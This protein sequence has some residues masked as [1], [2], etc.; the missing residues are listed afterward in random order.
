MYRKNNSLDV[1]IR[2]F[3]TDRQR[4]GAFAPRSG[5]WEIDRAGNPSVSRKT[6]MVAETPQ[7]AAQAFSN[8]KEGAAR[9]TVS[10]NGYEFIR[11]YFPENEPAA[12]WR[13]TK[14]RD[15]GWRSGI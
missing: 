10:R 14:A 2:E 13:K 15:R 4:N 7:A 1:S 8:S 6:A 9:E 11:R 5:R 12:H 3:G